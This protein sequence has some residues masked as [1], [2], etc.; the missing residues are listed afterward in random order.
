MSIGK[1]TVAMFLWSMSKEIRETQD[2]GKG[3]KK[4]SQLLKN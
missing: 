3:G 4:K 1:I 2:K